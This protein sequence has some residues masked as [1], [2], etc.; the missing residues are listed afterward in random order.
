MRSRVFLER[1]NRQLDARERRRAESLPIAA[2]QRRVNHLK[3]WAERRGIPPR[4]TTDAY[5]EG[6]VGGM[7][8]IQGSVY[9]DIVRN[10]GTATVSKSI[11]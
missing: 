6:V 4:Q 11:W 5:R 8:E 1:F 7:D 9:V 3:S 2:M 10:D